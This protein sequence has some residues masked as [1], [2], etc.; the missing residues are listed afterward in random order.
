MYERKM[1]ADNWEN[2]KSKAGSVGYAVVLSFTRC[3][4]LVEIMRQQ[5]IERRV[6]DL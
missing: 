4:T 1:K 3:L 2:H 6:R 5:D